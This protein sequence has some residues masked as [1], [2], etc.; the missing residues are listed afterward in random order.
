MGGSPGV[1]FMGG[2]SGS[3]G[4]EFESQHLLLDGQISTLI[5]CKKCI[6]VL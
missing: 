3:E 1:E 4:H 6:D 5:Y 2:D